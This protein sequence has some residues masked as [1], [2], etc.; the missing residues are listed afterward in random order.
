MAKILNIEESDR[1]AQFA[2]LQK[3]PKPSYEYMNTWDKA[4]VVM[5]GAI[6]FGAL[7]AVGWM[8]REMMR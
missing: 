4:Y 2:E 8:V 1:W 7:W 5:G 3:P 6:L